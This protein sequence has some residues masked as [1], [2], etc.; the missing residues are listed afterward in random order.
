MGVQI[1]R[2]RL[3]C[4]LGRCRGCIA[5]VPDQQQ[6]VIFYV[7]TADIDDAIAYG[8]GLRWAVFGPCQVFKFASQTSEQFGN[9]ID[10]IVE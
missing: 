8:P 9:F 2:I 7:E 4:H 10:M 3:N 5:V 6:A 1:L